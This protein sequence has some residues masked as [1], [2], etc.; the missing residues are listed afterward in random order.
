MSDD[1]PRPDPSPQRAAAPGALSPYRLTG[2]AAPMVVWAVHFVVVYSLQGVTCG[3]GL[4]NPRIA[5]LETLTWW[6][7]A[8]T[9]LSF[10]A[11][12]WMGLRAWRGW[13]ASNVD[14]S[15]PALAARRRF[16]AAVTALLCALSAV[17]VLFTT[18]P[19]LLLPGCA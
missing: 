10:A 3:E 17:A 8:L 13:R 14:R 2:L 6:V 4:A 18:L 15:T 19:V 12:A 7:L 5:G 9:V 11:L 16:S 1:A